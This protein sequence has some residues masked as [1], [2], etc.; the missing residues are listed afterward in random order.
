MAASKEQ[1]TSQKVIT[2]IPLNIEPPK[3]LFVDPV[4]VF[5]FTSLY[6]TVIM[7]YNLC[8]T[9]CLGSIDEII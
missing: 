8:F 9:T 3:Q 4:L 5:D 7:A 2:G 6:P 1:V